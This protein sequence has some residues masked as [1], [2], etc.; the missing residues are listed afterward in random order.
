M[1]KIAR[2][3]KNNQPKIEERQD[4]DKFMIISNMTKDAERK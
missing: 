2:K 3:V 1:K 4:C